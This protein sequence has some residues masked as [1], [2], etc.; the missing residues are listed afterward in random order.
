[1]FKISRLLRTETAMAMKTIVH[2]TLHKQLSN[3]NQTKPGYELRCS[4]GASS[5]STMFQI[6][7]TCVARV[8]MLPYKYMLD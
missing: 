7:S 1:M 6:I 3:M 8:T 4:G 5:V 2:K